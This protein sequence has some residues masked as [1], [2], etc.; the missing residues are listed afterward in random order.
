MP[1]NATALDPGVDVDQNVTRIVKILMA[2]N[3]LDQKR[4][5]AAM[6][7]DPAT[8]TRLFKGR[9]EWKLTE[10]KRLAL[11]FDRPM[12][13]FFEMPEDVVRSRWDR[14]DDLGFAA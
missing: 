1:P 2:L 8:V 9:R 6:Q 3:G 12:G 11:L 7:M 14:L 4:F 10:I 13:Y 5:A